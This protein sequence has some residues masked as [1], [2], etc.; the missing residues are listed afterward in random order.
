[1]EDE[2]DF[3]CEICLKKFTR[4]YNL[5]THYNKSKKCQEKRLDNNK[6]QELDKRDKIIEQKD[7]TIIEDKN[8]KIQRTIMFQINH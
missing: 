3:N 1:M 4:K 7:E 2:N 5:E 8:K 6:I